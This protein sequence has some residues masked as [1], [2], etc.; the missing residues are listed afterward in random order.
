[1]QSY[2]LMYRLGIRPW[3]RYGTA[4][5]G[6]IGRMLDREEQGARGSTPGSEPRWDTGSP[7]SRTPGPRCWYRLLRS[8]GARG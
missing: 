3:E 1:M 7:P 8:A 5:A 4:A 6:T 2:A